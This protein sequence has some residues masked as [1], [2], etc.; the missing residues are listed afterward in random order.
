ML[1]SAAICLASVIYAEARG[2][3]VDGQIA[4]AQVVLNRIEDS[5]WPDSICGIAEQPDQFASL[6]PDIETLAVALEVI[7]EEHDDMV[8]GAT[9]FFS[10][11]PPWW[12]GE[13]ERIGRIAGHTFMREPDWH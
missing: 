10:G 11:P 8:A 13:M 6:P 5:R 1:A 9:H 4:V 3:P 12:A 7:R 2:E